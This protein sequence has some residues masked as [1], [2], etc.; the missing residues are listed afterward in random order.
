MKLIYDFEQKYSSTYK[1][2]AR[3]NDIRKI[4]ENAYFKWIDILRENSTSRI[5]FIKNRRKWKIAGEAWIYED[6]YNS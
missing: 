1:N 5:A 4:D 3:L 2:E 6:N